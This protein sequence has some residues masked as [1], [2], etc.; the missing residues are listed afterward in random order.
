VVGVREPPGDVQPKPKSGLVLVRLLV[1]PRISLEDPV[2]IGR[3]D[4]RPLILD[5]HQRVPAVLAGRQ[6]NRRPGLGVGGG[7]VEQVAEDASDRQR[8]D[9]HQQ[10]PGNRDDDVMVGVR[11]PRCP[12]CVFGQGGGV[13]QRPAWLA[14]LPAVD[15]R[16]GQELVEQPPKLLTLPVGDTQ[17]LVLLGI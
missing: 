15:G 3:W 11:Q 6:P 9:P 10:R 14:A 8:V 5:G 2:T 17:Q 4:P 7:G 1:Q 13:D 12:T 16:G